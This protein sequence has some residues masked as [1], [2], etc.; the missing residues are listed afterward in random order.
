[1]PAVSIILLAASGPTNKSLT[2]AEPC[3]ARFDKPHGVWA[4]FSPTAEMQPT[5]MLVVV[6]VVD[7]DCVFLLMCSGEEAWY[8]GLYGSFANP[9]PWVGDDEAWGLWNDIGIVGTT[10]V[11]FKDCWG[12]RHSVPDFYVARPSSNKTRRLTYIQIIIR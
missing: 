10:S 1:M 9:F 2:G 5:A 6:A 4:G 8:D 3:G 11:I 7:A 12:Q